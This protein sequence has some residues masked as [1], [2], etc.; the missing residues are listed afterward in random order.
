ML[1]QSNPLG[2][3]DIK[4]KTDCFSDIKDIKQDTPVMF[5]NSLLRIKPNEVNIRRKGK[6]NT[7]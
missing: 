4:D 6:I 7:M 5:G 1:M 3:S 2:K